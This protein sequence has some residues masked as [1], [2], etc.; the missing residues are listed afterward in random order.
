MRYLID[1]READPETALALYRS[2]LA[3][4]AIRGERFVLRL[5]TGI[6]D[7][8]A[9]VTRLCALGQTTAAPTVGPPSG[10]PDRI[11]AKLFPNPEDIV[12][13]RG[14]PDEAFVRELT[15]KP[16]PPR[17]VSGDVSPV[18][19]VMVLIGDR[20]LYSLSDYGRDQVLNLTEEELDSLRQTLRQAGL[21]QERVI[22]APS[23]PPHLEG[24]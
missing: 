13:V 16:A 15:R 21:E 19:D 23:F 24:R 7:D 18:E 20:R 22:P 1:D 6:Y 2:T 11:L 17:A 4:A 3:W 14:T 8:P 9:D 5:Q 12:E 10:L